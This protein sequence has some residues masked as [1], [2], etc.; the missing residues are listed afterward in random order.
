MM[1]DSGWPAMRNRRLGLMTLCA[2]LGATPLR[3]APPEDET[4]VAP[5]R[6]SVDHPEY[7]TQPLF[8]EVFDPSKEIPADYPV[9]FPVDT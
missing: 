6:S 1:S 4:A 9:P 5:P 3:A 8:D 7:Q 2:L